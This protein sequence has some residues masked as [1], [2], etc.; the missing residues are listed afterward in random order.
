MNQNLDIK[1]Y[2][3]AVGRRIVPMIIVTLV[4]FA[5]AC[6]VAYLLPTVYRSEAKILVESQR[7]PT[8][9]AQATITAQ[10]AERI[11]RLHQRMMTRDNLL[12]IARE[13]NLYPSEKIALSST[14]IVEIMRRDAQ[15]EP[16]NAGSRSTEQAIA[17]TVS[18]EYKQ[19]AVT[20]RVANRFVEL[21][22]EQNIR[23]RT[24]R[25]TETREF[26]DRQLRNR[27]EEFS[28]VEQRII[29]FK[30]ENRST[31]PDT[32]DYRRERLASTQREI[33]DIEQKLASLA[34]E[35][36]LLEARAEGA[37]AGSIIDNGSELTVQEKEL[38]RLQLLLT[39]LRSSYSDS[40]P[41]VRRVKAQ[42]AAMG[43]VDNLDSVSSDKP[44]SDSGEE[45]SALETKIAYQIDLATRQIASLT[46][47]R[48]I[49]ARRVESLNEA[50]AR[51]PETEASLLALINE[52]DTLLEQQRQLATKI[53]LAAVGERLEEN[54]QAERFEILEQAT[55]PTEPTKPNRPLIVLGG[56]F[57]SLGAGIGMV[58]LL[59][60]MDPTLRGAR[61]LE[62]HFQVRPIVSV[63]FIETDAELLI[64]KRKRFAT[65]L[66]SLTSIIAVL[67]VLHTY[68]LPLDV[69]VEKMLI[70]A[71][72]FA[73]VG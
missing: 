18:F 38:R 25:A 52:R 39:Q 60:M 20:A 50:N 43:K 17:F 35:K 73:I 37:K 1:I 62:G 30:N 10:A 33:A 31:L 72:K 64:R 29:K 36:K 34:E 61:A 63:P 48:G 54:R 15:I 53:D 27:R 4:V 51:T 46:A 14:E 26:F 47:S 44:A 69:I 5:A 6:A 23:S 19:P 11:Q 45:V 41:D 2:L 59:E 32:L 55:A 42:I 71:R 40:H 16:I 56:F 13:F 57:A 7:I 49:L 65:V 70:E 8:D 12:T 24:A 9:L 21:I 28:N 66:I 22:L 68:Y 58:L 67:F 3:R